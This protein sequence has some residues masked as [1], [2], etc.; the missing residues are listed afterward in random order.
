MAQCLQTAIAKGFD[1]ELARRS[2][3]AVTKDLQEILILEER[4]TNEQTINKIRQ[5]FWSRLL[6]FP[7]EFKHHIDNKECLNIKT[8]Y[9]IND[10]KVIVFPKLTEYNTYPHL[11]LAISYLF[12]FTKNDGLAL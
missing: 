9:G 11:F 12:I 1:I 7:E 10:P 5:L 3:R 6:E 2:L 8:V 4:K